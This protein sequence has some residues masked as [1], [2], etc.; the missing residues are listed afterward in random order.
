MTRRWRTRAGVTAVAL[1]LLAGPVAATAVTGT[2]GESGA[3]AYPEGTD[4]AWPDLHGVEGLTGGAAELGPAEVVPV[5]ERLHEDPDVT[6]DPEVT[7][8]PD[9]GEQPGA[10]AADTTTPRPVDVP[11]Q[12]I[13]G[14]AEAPVELKQI[15]VGLQPY[16]SNRVNPVPF[17]RV[18]TTGVRVFRADWDGRVYDHPIAQAQYALNTLESY[19]LTGERQYLDVAIANAQRIID[20]R[21]VIDGAWYFPYDFDFDLFRNG[22]G[23]LTAPWASGMASGQALSTF[24]RLHEVTGERR[25]R[26]AADAT[27]R[28]F[29]QAPDGQGYFS[30]F[31]DTGGHLWLEEYSRYPVMSSERVLNG[32]MWSMYGLWDYWMM[33]DHDH[34]DA[35]WLFRGALRT[36]ETTVLPGFRNPGWSSYYSLWQKQLGHTYHQHHQQQFLMLYRMS[37][38]P[39]WISHA[40]TYRSD[41]PEW[42]NTSGFAVITPRTTVAYRLDDSAVHI[43][44][45]TMRVLESRSLAL[46][47]TTGAPFDRRG[48]IPGGPTVIRLSDGF[49]AG[50]WIV[51]GFDRAWSRGLVEYHA[52]VPVDAELYVDEDVRVAVYR[53]DAAGTQTG[54]KLVTL[55]AG[56]TYPTDR[57]AY[58]AGRTSYQLTG[59]GLTGWWLAQQPLVELRQLPGR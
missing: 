11:R 14:F 34:P 58:L 25:W 36:L 26:D 45:R 5:P 2:G 54:S 3:T 50:W 55:K 9:G 12:R 47:R 56:A 19:R 8:E 38:D 22:Q 24:V 29:L 40:D 23:V 51:E 37:H 57:S 27:F 21:H 6:G 48:K 7:G 41:F 52:Y 1:A 46:D 44:D 39:L 30:S 33:Y 4:E 42:R 43:K 28:A 31:V 16:Q 32:H 18:D 35:E 17:G 10:T 20:R 15:P 53:Y 59:G 13:A 49:L